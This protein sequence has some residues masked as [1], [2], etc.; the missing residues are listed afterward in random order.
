MRKIW[1]VLLIFAF[2]IFMAVPSATFAAAK[3]S[4]TEYDAG[5]TV[6]I[7]GNI[8]PGQDLYIAI[9]MQDKFAPKDTTGPHEVKTFK[10]DSA[11]LLFAN[12]QSW[13]IW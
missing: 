8:T 1:P 12:E 13:Q 9:A 11:P 7:E 3:L 10:G 6:T 4:A 5:D 2:A